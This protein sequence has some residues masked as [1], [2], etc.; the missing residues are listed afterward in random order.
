MAVYHTNLAGAL[1]RLKDPGKRV[2]NLE[3][4]AACYERAQPVS[5]T[6]DYTEQI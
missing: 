5:K 6:E 2:D 4:A 3:Q 1:E